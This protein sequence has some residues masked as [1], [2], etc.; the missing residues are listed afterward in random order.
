VIIRFDSPGE[1]EFRDEN[2]VPSV[3]PVVGKVIVP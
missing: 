2:V 3:A 1:Y